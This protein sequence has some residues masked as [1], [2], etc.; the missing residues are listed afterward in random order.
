M[1]F[2]SILTIWILAASALTAMAV[3]PQKARATWSSMQSVSRNV[4]G[5]TPPPPP[6]PNPSVTSEIVSK[7]PGSSSPT[8]AGQAL[9]WHQWAVPPAPI[10]LDF[11]ADSP[12]EHAIEVT[13][14]KF[15]NRAGY[16]ADALNIRWTKDSDLRHFGDGVGDGEYI[17]ERERNEPSCFVADRQCSIKVRLQAKLSGQ[18]ALALASATMHASYVGDS[19]YLTGWLNLRE[20]E[21]KFVNGVSR[22][23]DGTEYVLFTCEKKVHGQIYQAMGHY[24]FYA[25]D[26][27]DKDRLSVDTPNIDVKVDETSRIDVY[28]VLGNPGRPWYSQAEKSEAWVSALFFSI[29]YRCVTCFESTPTGALDCTTVALHSHHGLKYDRTE[30]RSSYTGF[31]Y[32]TTPSDPDHPPPPDFVQFD[33]ESYMLKTK[34]FCNCHDQAAAVAVLGNL[35]A[36]ETS[37][38]FYFEL[39]GYLATS[40]LVGGANTNNPVNLATITDP[41]TGRRYSF[42][43][44]DIVPTDEFF[45]DMDSDG[46]IDRS[47]F[48]NHAFVV[49]TNL[50]KDACCGPFT[51]LGV[52]SYIATAS[53]RTSTYETGIV[54]RNPSTGVLEVITPFKDAGSESSMDLFLRLE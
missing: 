54:G 33:L 38:A 21:V 47:L 40:V 51:D 52:S 8:P 41:T 7:I 19:A 37:T 49:T 20:R 2:S 26:L 18:P 39:F 29:I 13:H 42:D 34:T 30:S 31:G 27:L 46:D 5:Q 9:S 50:V 11:S 3:L 43:T 45:A 14:I 15:D 25:K 53:D 17:P 12:L 44:R 10:P 6:P 4:N 22:G 16:E 23:D 35:V 32:R 24:E 36:G 1:K 48:S 28:T